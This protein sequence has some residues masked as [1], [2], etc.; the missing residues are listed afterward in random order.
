MS[1]LL[2]FREF[3]GAGV[4]TLSWPPELDHLSASS[5]GMLVRCPRQFQ[6]RYLFHEKEK[7]GESLIVGT[8]MHSTLAWN[9][10]T[11]VSSGKDQPVADMV[12]YLNDEAIHAAIK[13]AGGIDNVRW[14]S[15]PE[16]ARSDSERITS[17]YYRQVV[18]RIQPVAV[19]EQFTLN[20]E[21]VRVPVIGYLDTRESERV[22]DVKSG[23]AVTRK[24]KPSWQLQGRLYSLATRLP[25]EYH[26]VSRAKT[27]GIVTALESED[28]VIPVPSDGQVA[29]MART[30]EMA[31]ATISYY[32]ERYGMDQDWPTLGAIPD[33]SRNVL[34]C[35]LCGWREG[36]PAWS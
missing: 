34:P 27:P 10:A 20:F 31:S 2:D 9:Y 24:V 14:D 17:A 16:T 1:K 7:P 13:E 22:L 28:M 36:C 25:T 15:D 18:P 35:D 21:S 12:Q 11:K 4:D 32:W 5:V 30:L 6:R 3:M 8:T 26:S 33:W 29:E 23:R 19:E